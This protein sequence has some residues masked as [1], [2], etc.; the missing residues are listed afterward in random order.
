MNL[1]YRTW[2]VGTGITAACIPALRPGYKALRNRVSTYYSTHYGSVSHTGGSRFRS[3]SGRHQSRDYD[4]RRDALVGSHMRGQSSSKG[5]ELLEMTDLAHELTRPGAAVQYDAVV[6]GPSHL[7]N[8]GDDGIMVDME[9]G[10][11]EIEGIKKTMWFGTKSDQDLRVGRHVE[12]GERGR[13]F[14]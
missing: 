4:G 1:Y 11:E 5:D 2:E 14:I 7:K 8:A 13:G 9:T 6:H 3:A 10:N 12:R